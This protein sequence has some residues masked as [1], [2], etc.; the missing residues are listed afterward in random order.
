MDDLDPIQHLRKL[1]Y[2]RRSG[3]QGEEKAAAYVAQVLKNGGS[4]PAV[5]EFR[6]TKPKLGSRIFLP[7]LLLVWLVLSLVNIRFWNSNLIVSLFVLLLPVALILVMLNFGRLTRFFS[8][9][10]I[11]KLR[12]VE[13]EWEDGTLKPD[14]VITSRNVIAEIGPENAEKQILFTAH[15]DSISLRIPTRLMTISMVLGFLGLLI[16]SV[17]YLINLI[18]E[19]NF[20]AANFPAFVV[21]ASFLV[22]TLGIVFVSRSLRGNQSHGIIDDGTGVAILLELARFVKAHPIPGYRF[23]FGFFGSEESGLVGSTYD[24]INREV[25]KEKLRVV[26]VDMIREKPPLAYVKRIA[27]VRGAHMD[28]VLN[29]QIVAIAEALGIE[30]EGKNFP[31]PGSD[32]GPYMLLGGC[33]ANWFISRSRLIHSKN[34]HLG[35]VNQELVEDALKLIVAYLLQLKDRSLEQTS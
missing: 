31:Y 2:P 12:K 18:V 3:T 19:S 8:N 32:F 28:A 30:I 29:Q 27:L 23:I 17:L 4:E 14:Q 22:I 16:Y 24:F 13:K 9:R 34:D 15:L 33:T 1:D 25:D 7:L 20:M 6:Y 35:N 21:F 10:R 26:S 11:A 5:S